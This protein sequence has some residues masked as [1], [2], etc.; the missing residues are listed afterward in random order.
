MK[1]LSLLA[2]LLLA[3]SVM[4]ADLKPFHPASRTAIEQAHAGQPF[5]LAFWS[6]DCAYCPEEIRHL[7]ALVRKRPDIRLVLVSVDGMEMKSEVGTK[8]AEYLP[9]G[10][11]ER[12]IFAADDPDRLYFAIDRKWHGELPRTYFYDGKGDV[13]GRSGVVS[14]TWLVEWARSIAR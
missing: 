10:K 14:S 3:Q 4:A 6:V 8:L 12:W 1:R 13:Q 9:D 7:G 11:G 5:V 2:L